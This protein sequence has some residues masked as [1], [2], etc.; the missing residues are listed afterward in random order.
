MWTW[1]M[2][3]FTSPVV[4]AWTEVAASIATVVGWFTKDT[5]GD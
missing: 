5:D 2:W 4:K 1:I 3:F